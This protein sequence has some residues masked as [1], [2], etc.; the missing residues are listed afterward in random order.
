MD[1]REDG[2]LWE[3]VEEVEN[4]GSER[5]EVGN[6]DTEGYEDGNCEDSETNW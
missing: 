3:D 4:V 5:D 1:E 6:N 2:I